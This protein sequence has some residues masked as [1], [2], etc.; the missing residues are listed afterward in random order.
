MTVLPSQKL[1]VSQMNIALAVGLMLFLLP[2]D[3]KNQFQSEP[4]CESFIFVTTAIIIS[5]MYIIIKR[6]EAIGTAMVA[7]SVLTA[8]AFVFTSV[9]AIITKGMDYWPKISEYQI[10][11]MFILWVTPFVFAVALRLIMNTS[12]KKSEQR[13]SFVRFLSLSMKALIIIYVMVLVFKL[14]I[15]VKPH[16]ENEREL[17]PMLSQR[18]APCI[19]GEHANGIEYI[20]WHC[21]IIA[22]LT[23][24]LSVLIPEFRVW[25]GVIIAVALGLT[26]E[27]IQFLLNTGAA[28]S[29]DIIMYTSGALLGIFL[30]RSIDFLRR[31]ITGGKEAVILS[32]EY[33]TGLS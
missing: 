22:P 11:S 6:F 18:I 10:V 8:A 27:A 4:V 1:S 14:I 9:T 31:G 21:I 28:C 26:V 25:H 23:F 13:R 19:T 17:L 16:T 29:D 24:Y 7:T 12:R 5:L 32:Y 20:I 2:N 30:K 33:Q 15:P 3:A